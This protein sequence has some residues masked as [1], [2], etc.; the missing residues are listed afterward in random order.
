MS[1]SKNIDIF[2]FIFVILI[3]DTLNELFELTN[4]KPDT[5]L[6]SLIYVLTLVR[7]LHTKMSSF[8]NDTLNSQYQLFGKIDFFTF[9]AKRFLV[10]KDQINM[11]NF[12]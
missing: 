7:Y 8:Y 2:F 4:V 6:T 11:Y 9:F 1:Q 3:L 12:H 5:L 10:I